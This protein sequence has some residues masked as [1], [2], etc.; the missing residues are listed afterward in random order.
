MVQQI[1]LYFSQYPKKITNYK[2][3]PGDNRIKICAVAFRFIANR[4]TNG[5]EYFVL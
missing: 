1:K 4:Q 5:A 3:K 2:G